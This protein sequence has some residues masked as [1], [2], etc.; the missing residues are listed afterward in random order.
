MK[1]IFYT[2]LSVFA[3]AMTLNSCVKDT[4]YATPQLHCEEP[5]IN[6]DQIL[7]LETVLDNWIISNDVN[8]DGDADDYDDTENAFEFNDEEAPD[9]Y[10]TGYVVS[11]DK[12]GNF[13]KELYIQDKL[14]DPDAAVKIAIDMPGLFAKYNLGRKVYIK[15]NGLAI[16][17]SHGEMVIGRLEGTRIAS[18]RENVAK[19]I[20]QRNCE[21]GEL[22]AKVIEDLSDINN[23]M[24]GMYVQFDNMQFTQD[25]LGNTF[26]DPA[27]SYDSHRAMESCAGS[28]GI[29]LETST[30]ASYKDSPLPS[31]QGSVTGILSRDYGDDNYVL[32]VNSIEA[33]D[34][35]GSRC[36]ALFSDGFDDGFDKWNIFNLV[37][38]QEWD[39]DAVHGNPGSCAKISGY[40]GGAHE[41][42]DWM[43]SNLIDLNT[44]TTASLSFQTAMNYSGPDLEVKY[45]IDYDGESDPTTAT[46][47]TIDATL[48]DGGWEWTDSGSIDISE[49]TG[50]DFYLAFVYVSTSS[51]SATFEVDNVKVVA[52]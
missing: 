12:T 24:L 45:S 35:E 9:V 10:I 11:D 49:A 5:N 13:Y 30:Y 50:N 37:G 27:D 2:T 15:I 29:L 22:V 14:E 23:S 43:I 25:L 19:Q 39:I 4:D 32:R 47:V 1:K 44:V 40:A 26:V 31:G 46:W 6:A 21:A 51:A 41:N 52:E 16:N 28:G 20:I 17:K 38:D 8:G 36:D 18:I 34:F 33:F 7:P 3:I 48:S 42:E